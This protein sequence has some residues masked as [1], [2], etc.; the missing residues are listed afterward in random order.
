MGSYFP[1]RLLTPTNLVKVAYWNGTAEI[2]SNCDLQLRS[3]NPAQPNELPMCDFKRQCL[4]HVN[5]SD[6]APMVS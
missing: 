1:F 5:L 4:L 2:S 3:R 6:L